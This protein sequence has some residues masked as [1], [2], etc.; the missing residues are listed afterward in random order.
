MRRT[1]LLVL[2]FSFL[3]TAGMAADEN[4]GSGEPDL[5]GFTANPAEGMTDPITVDDLVLTQAEEDNQT[6]GGIV[7]HT[8]SIDVHGALWTAPGAGVNRTTPLAADGGQV[9]WFDEAKGYGVIVGTGDMDDD[10]DTDL[11]TFDLSGKPDDETEPRASV[12]KNPDDGNLFPVSIGGSATVDGTTDYSGEIVLSQGGDGGVQVAGWQSVTIPGISVEQGSYREGNEAKHE[13]K[14]W[15]QPTFDDLE[16]ERG[17]K[18]DDTKLHDWH[19]AIQ[20]GKADA[21]RKEI[22]VKMQDEEGQATTRFTFADAWPKEYNPPSL[23]ATA[24]GDMTTESITVAFDA[25]IRTEAIIQT[26]PDSNVSVEEIKQRTQQL[27]KQAAER[28]QANGRKTVRPEDLRAVTNDSAVSTAVFQPDEGDKVD[29]SGYSAAVTVYDPEGKLL[30]WDGIKD[31]GTG[32]SIDQLDDRKQVNLYMNLYEDSD[33]VREEGRDTV[34]IRAVCALGAEMNCVSSEG[35]NKAH[36]D[37]HGPLRTGRFTVEGSGN[38]S[39]IAAGESV[40]FTAD[41]DD[42]N[43]TVASYE[44]TVDGEQAGSGSTLTDMLDDRKQ[45]TVMLEWETADGDAGSYSRTV[46][47]GGPVSPDVRISLNDTLDD[48]EHDVTATLAAEASDPDGTVESYEWTVD[49]E[50][51]ST[52][53][54]CSGCVG[55]ESFTLRVTDDDGE[56]TT[57]SFSVG[58]N[59]TVLG[60]SRALRPASIEVSDQ[61]AVD[62]DSTNSPVKEGETLKVTAT[63]TNTGE[64]TGTQEATLTTGGTQRDSTTMELGPGDSETVELTWETADGDA[65]SYTSPE[66]GGPYW[67]GSIY[68]G[69]DDGDVTVDR[70]G[71]MKTGRFDAMPAPDWWDG[72]NTVVPRW[73]YEGVQLADRHYDPNKLPGTAKRVMEDRMLVD[74]T[75]ATTDDRVLGK[76]FGVE[77]GADNQIKRASLV[78]ADQFDAD[79]R[80]ETDV[81]TI[82]TIMGAD[83]TGDVAMAAYRDGRIDV[84]GEGIFNTVKYAVIDKLGKLAMDI[85]IVDAP[86]PKKF[87]PGKDLA[88]AAK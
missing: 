15:G 27:I 65:G 83:N 7:G 1:V 52:D 12:I 62:I 78:S 39:D 61:F 13:K 30:A 35:S 71:P 24:A 17:V 14:L 46:S 4:E 85:G 41:A 67:P 75:G 8:G 48:G 58:D 88:E 32:R 5:P 6:L 18:P 76:A 3:V 86:S 36:V 51:L 26:D 59:E 34:G 2:T 19:S 73:L 55:W 64:E 23:D 72:T 42:P 10:G 9:K 74:V 40:T 37:R 16:M 53:V 29:M 38:M 49:G 87:K 81:E 28:A 33:T 84:K 43:G 22:A 45:H 63:V 25:M 68:V 66:D 60:L 54:Q 31:G 56:S 20:A 47:A 80:I 69:P 11:A 57:V 79:V 77:L 44:W 70:H 82:R 21:A 50:V